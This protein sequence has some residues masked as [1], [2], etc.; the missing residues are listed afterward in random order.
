VS[1]IELEAELEGLS[2]IGMFG[3]LYDKKQFIYD[4]KHRT[5]F[6]SRAGDTHRELWDGVK[7]LNKVL[8]QKLGLV[9]R[10]HGEGT[11]DSPSKLQLVQ[12]LTINNK[13]SESAVDPKAIA[14]RVEQVRLAK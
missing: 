2:A 4:L 8:E 14:I 12:I 6:S 5:P 11:A 10:S 9:I 7:A 13:R 1:K 3:G